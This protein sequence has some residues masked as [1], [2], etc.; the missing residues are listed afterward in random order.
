MFNSLN[1]DVIATGV[2]TDQQVEILTKFDISGVQGYGIGR[3]VPFD[4]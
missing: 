1:I 2:E 4:E 3:P